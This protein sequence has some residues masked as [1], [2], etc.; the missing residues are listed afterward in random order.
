MGDFFAVAI[1]IKGGLH[2][3]LAVFGVVVLVYMWKR[4]KKG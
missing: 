4:L 1:Q 3:M 2:Y